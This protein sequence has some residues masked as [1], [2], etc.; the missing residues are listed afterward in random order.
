[1]ELLMLRLV[2]I[3]SLLFA[4]LFSEETP[5]RRFGENNESRRDVIYANLTGAAV[6]TAWGIANWDYGKNKPHAGKE[7][8]FSHDTKSGGADKLG[9]FYGAYLIGSSLSGLYAYWGYEKKEAALY[10]SLSSFLVMNYMEFGD[11]FSSYG[12]SYE[13][14]VMNTLG[15]ASAYL[16]SAHPKLSRKVDF[17]IE[18]V[19]S[20]QTADVVTEYEKMKYLIALKAEGF[21]SI[22]HPYLRYGELHLGYYTRNYKGGFSSQSERI[23]YLGVGINL[24]RLFRQN[25]YEKTARFFNYYQLPYTY[26]PLEKELND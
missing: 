14:F 9:H 5:K 16:L 1:M 6:I 20:F 12:F 13:D 18:Y 15:A 10:G 23:I 4:L 17:R 2:I 19:P 7:G 25:G 21:E 24:S 3:L 8:W 26:L 22:T 11:A